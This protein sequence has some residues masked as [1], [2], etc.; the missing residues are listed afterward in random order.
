MKL[1]RYR[2]NILVKI[3]AMKGIDRD[4]LKQVV[5]FDASRMLKACKCCRRCRRR[6][7]QAK[8]SLC[9]EKSLLKD[10]DAGDILRMSKSLA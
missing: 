1:Q 7:K 3:V 9:K 5:K 2:N 10:W 6:L 8:A 4:L